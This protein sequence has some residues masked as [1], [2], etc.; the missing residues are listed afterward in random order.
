VNDVL[1]ET[2]HIVKG[3]VR[4]RAMADNNNNNSGRLGDGKGT[5]LCTLACTV[6][7]RPGSRLHPTSKR[8]KKEK[9]LVVLPEY[10]YR[11]CVTC[12]HLSMLLRTAHRYADSGCGSTA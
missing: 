6:K 12:V 4:G 11:L 7:S 9:E 8:E 1:P 2:F 5:L 3:R 10:L